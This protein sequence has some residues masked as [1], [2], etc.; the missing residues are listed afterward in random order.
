MARPKS[1]VQLIEV[2]VRLRPETLAKL[3]LICIDPFVGKL[4]YGLRNQYLEEALLDFFA[5]N[6]PNRPCAEPADGG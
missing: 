4:Q 3:D 6:F 1:E 5:K 2:K